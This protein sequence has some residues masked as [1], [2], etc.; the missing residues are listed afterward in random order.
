M[1]LVGFMGSGKSTVGRLLA[2]RLGWT[3]VDVDATIEAGEGISVAEIFRCRGE[4]YFRD[5]E[6][7]VTLELLGRDHVVLGSG[8]GW[9]ASARRLRDLPDG[10][11]SV[12]LQVTPEEAVRR[13]S[14]AADER[15]LLAGGDPLE[16][17]RRLMKTRVEEYAAADVGVDTN[18][19]TPEDVVLAILEMIGDRSPDGTT[20]RNVREA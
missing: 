3:Y 10:T 19:R 8:G 4:P 16:T 12:W 17:A 11:T 9:G 13:V 14:A 20:A 15:P 2:D 1:V 6:S 5:V 7:R 18:A